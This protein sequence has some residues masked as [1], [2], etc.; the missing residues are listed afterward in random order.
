MYK[1][2]NFWLI[3]GD[4]RQAALAHALA[5]DG[6]SVHT[7]ALEE[8]VDP[9][10]VQ[11]SLT[12]AET[13]HCV[14]L[15]LPAAKGDLLNAPLSTHC[16]PLSQVLDALSPQQLICAGMV[17]PA[18]TQAAANR[19]LTLTDYFA[20]E[21]LAVANAV[22]SSEGAIQIA[23]EELPITLQDARVL[24]VG[25]GRLGKV[26]ARQ[27][28]GLGARVTVAARNPADRAW[29]RAWGYGDVPSD[30]LA[31]HTGGFDLICNTVP[32]C[33]LD[34]EAHR[35]GLQAR[36]G[37]LCRRRGVGDKGHLGPLSSRQSGSRHS[38]EGHP[39]RHLQHNDRVRSVTMEDSVRRIGFAFCGSFCTF[40]TALKALRAVK[41]RFGDVTVILSE[42][43]GSLD[44]R[45]GK[46]Q[47]FRREMEDISGK[48]L[49]DSL[50]AAEPIGPRKLLDALVICPCTGN[51]L[52]KL[53]NGV[54]DSTVALAA[55]AHLRNARPLILAV[56]T[57]D[58]LAGA[59]KN[60]GVL[61]DKKNTYFVPFR[62]D[63]PMGKP[64]S[65]VADFSL[66]PDTVAAALEGRQ[67]QPL[68][69]G[70]TN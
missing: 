24:V 49:I 27:L 10:W 65:L 12:G 60:I 1:P 15:P 69:L 16:P 34:R 23:M 68:V 30:H 19:S 35:P 38:R 63:D 70:P 50:T 53:A 5:E 64:T 18:L 37:G 13:A 41:D 3:G 39:I 14:I 7:Y 4:H 21:E 45:F 57:N 17:T 25:Y 58:A 22:P 59:A 29:V 66:V 56:S 36:R 61:L 46:A 33:L 42:N 52:G 26:L 51:T 54:T 40:D 47:D 11:S 32:V 55:K 28:H 48:P 6:H 9:A 2:L 20:R 8:G 31:G 44:T 43:S 67:L 62:Q